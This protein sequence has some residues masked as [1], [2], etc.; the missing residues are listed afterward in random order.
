MILYMILHSITCLVN[1]WT[2]QV[3][4]IITWHS[5]IYYMAFYMWLYMILHDITC[6]LQWLH[7]FYM[8]SYMTGYITNYMTHYSTS[9][10]LLHGITWNYMALLEGKI[11]GRVQKECCW[12]NAWPSLNVCFACLVIPPLIQAIIAFHHELSVPHWIGIPP[13]ASRAYKDS[14]PNAG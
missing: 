3:T 1:V 7:R 8:C 10:D 4:P 9:H 12:T 6:L 11:A 2:W 14:I 5:K 13:H